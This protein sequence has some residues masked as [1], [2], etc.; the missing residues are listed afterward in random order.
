M[1]T[2]LQNNYHSR[3]QTLRLCEKVS[4]FSFKNTFYPFEYVNKV[5]YNR[6]HLM[7]VWVNLQLKTHSN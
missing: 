7:K 3:F 1:K 6:Q 5:I 2:K 4:T